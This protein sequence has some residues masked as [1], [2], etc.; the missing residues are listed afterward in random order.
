MQNIEM[1]LLG[2]ALKLYYFRS[3]YKW[4]QHISTATLRGLLITFIEITVR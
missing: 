2:N 4:R 1:L 3:C